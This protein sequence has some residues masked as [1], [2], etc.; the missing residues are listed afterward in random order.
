M[1]TREAELFKDKIEVTLD[2]RQIFYLFF[3]GAVIACLVF[4]LGVTV[5]RRVEARQTTARAAGAVHDPLAALDEL[6]AESSRGELAFPAALRGEPGSPL[7]AVDQRIASG[8][9]VDGKP[10]VKP[11]EVA[12]AEVKP[13]AAH[14]DEAPDAEAATEAAAAEAA[15]KAAADKLA[16]DKLAADKAAAEKAARPKSNG[17]YTL[18][19]SSFQA[20]PEAEAYLEKMKQLGLA[21]YMVEAQVEGKGT[22]YRIRIGDY[23][24]DTEAMA[25]KVEFE[26]KNK[27]I[28]Y[29][30]RLK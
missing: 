13:A 22:W 26:A 7:A 27:I 10:V 6:D 28:A 17:K 4:I 2:G 25:A 21:P 9:P 11:A 15:R 14:D 16:A 12:P 19:L 20:K 29:V 30:T 5:G 18:Q 23:A 8:K 24:S 1:A 3:G